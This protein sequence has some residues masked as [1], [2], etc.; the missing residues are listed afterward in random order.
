MVV[1]DVPYTLRDIH[2]PL[3][4]NFKKVEEAVL[5]KVFGIDIELDPENQIWLKCADML[6]LIFHCMLEL[7]MGNT[8]VQP[9]IDRGMEALRDIPNKPKEIQ[10]VV[11]QLSEHIYGEK[12]KG[13]V[14]P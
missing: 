1:G 7:Y 4:Q 13:L 9:M 5:S 2:E 8:T 10:D 12:V 3:L 14:I 11:Y 6:E